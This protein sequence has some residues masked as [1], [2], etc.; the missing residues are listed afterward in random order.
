MTAYLHKLRYRGHRGTESSV[1]E[2]SYWRVRGSHQ[3][4]HISKFQWCDWLNE[5][6]Q[7]E[8]SAWISVPSSLSPLNSL[9]DT[10]DR[11]CLL[12]DLS[13]NGLASVLALLDLSAAFDPINHNILRG[14]FEPAIGIMEAALS[15]SES[16]LSKLFQLAHVNAK[17]VTTGWYKCVWRHE[18]LDNFNYS[19]FKFWEENGYCLNQNIWKRGCLV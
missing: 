14:R 2:D 16:H 18:N 7:R 1:F 8:K 5:L 19:A 6:L 13:A 15:R 3:L 12:L 11:F 17:S 10:S 4:C 9:H